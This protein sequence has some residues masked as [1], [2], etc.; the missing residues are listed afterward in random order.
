MQL[1]SGFM[2]LA[3][4][5]RRRNKIHFHCLLEG[6]MLIRIR[7][8][9]TILKILFGEVNSRIYVRKSRFTALLTHRRKL[10]FRPYVG[11]YTSPNENFEYSYPLI[12]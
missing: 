2:Q 11:R 5:G 6:K 3:V 8:G 1:P 10:N 9:I 12:D 4:A 7:M